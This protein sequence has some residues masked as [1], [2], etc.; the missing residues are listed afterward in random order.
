MSKKISYSEKHCK[1]FNG[2]IDNYKIKPSITVITKTSAYI[3][4]YDGGTIWMQFL[5]GGHDL[6]KK[7]NAIWNKIINS[8]KKKKFDSEHICNKKILETKIKSYNGEATDYCDK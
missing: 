3:K 8:I 1:Y 2:Y 7:Y 4:S 5:I 6:L